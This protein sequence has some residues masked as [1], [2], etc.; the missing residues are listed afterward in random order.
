[1]RKLWTFVAVTI[2]LSSCI[3]RHEK[4][5]PIAVISE[6]TEFNSGFKAVTAEWLPQQQYASDGNRV[7]EIIRWTS[8]DG[9]ILISDF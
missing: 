1:M 8:G 4:D 5:I 6:E 7:Y 2:L 9:N 3:M